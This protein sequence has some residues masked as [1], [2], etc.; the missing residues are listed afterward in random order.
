[1][2][3]RKYIFYKILE[4]ILLALIFALI[5]VQ[6]E[7]L[8]ADR[9]SVSVGI[10]NVRSG[11]GT[12]YKVLWKIEK[13]HPLQILRSS[14]GWYQFRDFE[15]DKAWIFKKLTSDTPTVVV[16][17]KNCNIRSGPGLNHPILFTAEY[18]VP[19]RVLERKEKWIHVQHSDG[20]KGWIYA[21]L[22]W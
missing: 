15:G 8:A 10:A 3:T 4:I 19:F 1:M 9:V 12:T 6:P 22:V 21:S 18:G 11:P 5:R 16:K 17:K 14:G 13:N 2:E 20:D 7:L